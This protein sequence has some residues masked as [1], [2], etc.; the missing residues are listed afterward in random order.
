MKYSKK[1]LDYLGSVAWRRRRLAKLEEV[2]WKC[3]RCPET[4]GLQVHHL[5]Y[6]NLGNEDTKELI[7]LCKACH[8][9]ADEL[10]KNPK[11]KI[12]EKL[13][14]PLRKTKKQL[15]QERKLRKKRWRENRKRTRKHRRPI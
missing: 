9:V 12:G 4:H 5:S 10:R 2:R 1:Y 14:A 15:K 13:Y 3:Q 11:S 7:V 6:D 8:W